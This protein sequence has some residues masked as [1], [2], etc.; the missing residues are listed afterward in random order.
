ML[1]R[2]WVHPDNM[3]IDK[4]SAC[5][6]YTDDP[7]VEVVNAADVEVLEQRVEALERQA[8]Q[9]H[10]HCD[11][12][13]TENAALEARVKELEAAFEEECHSHL[14]AV[15]KTAFDQQV[16]L[17]EQAQQRESRLRAALGQVVVYVKCESLNEC[18]DVCGVTYTCN[19]CRITRQAQQALHEEAL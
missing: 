14:G 10:E 5:L 15:A 16:T 17:K 18:G 13:A 19:N 2:W 9:C 8:D 11:I 1:Q 7:V 6:L 12:V 4:D 3:K